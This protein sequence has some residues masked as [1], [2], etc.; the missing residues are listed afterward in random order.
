[1]NFYNPIMGTKITKTIGF[2]N[3]KRTKAS[4]IPNL[5][6]ETIITRIRI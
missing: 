4:L 3:E 5:D 2:H 6:C 1:M